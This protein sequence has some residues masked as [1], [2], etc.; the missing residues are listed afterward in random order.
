MV[1]AKADVVLKKIIWFDRL[2]GITALDTPDK[3]TLI[4]IEVFM[5]KLYRVVLSALLVV[6]LALCA[7]SFAACA[8]SKESEKE[9]YTMTFMVGTMVYDT[10]TATE[11]SAYQTKGDP[12]RPNNVF[13][14]WS[15]AEDGAVEALPETMP[16]ENRTYYA[17]FSAQFTL[18]LDASFGSIPEEQASMTVK[19]GE[20]LY[21]KLSSITPTLASGDA[22]FDG[23]YLRGT[24]K[25]TEASGLTMPNGN[26]EAVAKYSVAYTV[27]IYKE[28]ELDSG[29]YGEPVTVLENTAFVG[30]TVAELPSY[31]GFRYDNDKANTALTDALSQYSAQNV[32]SLY[33]EV[34]GYEAEFSVNLPADAKYENDMKPL[35]CGYKL[36]CNMPEC[37][38]VADGYRFVGW[39][40]TPDGNVTYYPDDEFSID[41]ATIFYAKW[42][43]GLTELTGLSTDR[44]YIMGKVDDPTVTVA[45]LERA[46]LKDILG[47]YDDATHVFTFKSVLVE[48]GDVLLRGIADTARNTFTYLNTNNATAYTLLGATGENVPTITLKDDGK[49]TYVDENGDAVNATYFGDEDGSMKLVDGDGETMFAF[50]LVFSDD[51]IASYEVR[52]EEYGLWYNIGQDGYVDGKSIIYLD[53]YGFAQIYI[54]ALDS[55]LKQHTYVFGGTYSFTAGLNGAYDGEDGKEI[56]VTFYNNSLQAKS[57]VYLLMV[58]SFTMEGRTDQFT[59]VCLQRFAD[60]IYAAPAEGAAVDTATADK[61]VLSGYSVLDD[62]ATY[63]YKNDEGETVSVTGKYLYDECFGTI[64]IIPATGDKL[65]F[66]IFT[67]KDGDGNNVATFKRETGDKCGRYSTVTGLTNSSAYFDMYFYNENVAAFGFRLYKTDSFFGSIYPEYM[68]AIVGEYELI[69]ASSDPNDPSGNLYEFKATPDMS[70][71]NTIYNYLRINVISFYQFKF[72][73]GY[74]NSGAITHIAV[75]NTSDFVQGKFTYDGVEYTLDGYGNAVGTDAQGKE[76]KRSYAYNSLLGGV[77]VVN[78][79]TENNAQAKVMFADFDGDGVYAEFENNYLLSNAG[80]TVVMWFFKDNS[81]VLTLV[82]ATQTMAGPSYTYYTF[83]YGAITWNDEDKTVGSYERNTN[84]KFSSMYNAISE[85]YAAFKI[86]IVTNTT[87]NADG[88]TN[89]SKILYIYDFGSATP[90]DDGKYVIVNAAGDELM[91][92]ANSSNA[93]YIEKGAEGGNDVEYKGTYYY[94]DGTVQLVYDTNKGITFNLV[95]GENGVLSFEVVGNETG[96]MVDYN[97]GVSYLYLSGKSTGEAGVCSGTYYLYDAE[98]KAYTA[99][100]GTYRINQYGIKNGNENSYDFTYTVNGEEQTFTF[101]RIREVRGFMFFRTYTMKLDYYVYSINA[102]NIASPS[103]IGVLQGGEFADQQYVVMQSTGQ[104]MTYTGKL[105]EFDKENEIYVFTD[106]TNGYVFYFKYYGGKNMVRLDG[107]YVGAVKGVFDLSEPIEIEVAEVTGTPASPGVPAVPGVPAHTAV[108]EKVEMSGMAL[109]FLKYTYNG[110]E[111]TITAI[112]A[113]I[114]T[115]T[116]ILVDGNGKELARFRLMVRT[117]A[118]GEREYFADVIDRD[119]YGTFVNENLSVISLNGFTGAYYVDGYGMEHSGTYDVDENGVIRIAYID[120]KAY[121]LK[122]VYVTLDKEKGTFTLVSPSESEVEQPTE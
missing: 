13:E 120:M 110:E 47:T 35:L 46:G 98:T 108:I 31:T 85:T 12:V 114:A 48:N 10:V 11:G 88:T 38:Y 94:F 97:D 95:Y 118:S 113:Q 96:Y 51:G 90:N 37:G 89:V 81:A 3:R 78:I 72:Q 55:S 86:K 111:K 14:G 117:L 9:Q 5:K 80:T 53:G 44:V 109:A 27:N 87:E 115:S 4:S 70:V 91:L 60:T 103:P 65:V 68:V 41:R 7:F 34:I 15:N 74:D 69:V 63:T 54:I 42:V 61:I 17:V 104:P 20:N 24:E 57:F 122:Y 59:N 84:V 32:L 106:T 71:Y 56:V 22:K 92:D 23:W 67:G 101:A 6:V 76:L 112:Y 26:V 75:Q 66:E 30:D 19:V 29:N 18:K 82:Y 28:H 100:D 33:Y 16:S 45:Y 99:Y 121:V 2:S 116:F 77:L 107:A 1:S 40:T 49:A 43:K 21:S 83:S 102:S 58:G 39:A 79:P 105:E 62:S 36:A 52:G 8:D 64:T 73:F 119:T 93:T 50:R 25:I